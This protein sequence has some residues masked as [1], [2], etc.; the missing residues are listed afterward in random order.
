MIRNN[1]QAFYFF[2]LSFVGGLVFTANAQDDSLNVSQTEAQEVVDTS[3]VILDAYLETKKLN[4]PSEAALLGA[5]L[6]GFG[7]IYNKQY[8]KIPIVY[9]G[10]VVFASLIDYNHVRYIG[11][12]DALFLKSD[13]DPDTNPDGIYA[14]FPEDQ[15]RRG[16]DLY[17]RDRDFNIILTFMWYGLTI[18][19]ATVDA[20]LKDFDVSDNLSASIKPGLVPNDANIFAPGV[21]FVLTFK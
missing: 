15:L 16:R 6:P 17:R 4:E 18:A 1:K 2:L 21:R 9:G 13:G 8:W 7:Q 3:S 19:D 11:F 12:R 14:D 10:Y 20:H 5:I